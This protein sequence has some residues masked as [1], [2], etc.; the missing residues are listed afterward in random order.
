M[1]ELIS[2][3]VPC[4]NAEKTIDRCIKSVVEQTYK[5]WELIIVDDG[6]KDNSVQHVHK[7][8]TVDN[9][10]IFYGQ[11]NAGV[12]ATRNKA[13][14]LARGAYLA[15]LD[16]DDWYEPCFLQEL[17]DRLKSNH[18]DIACCAYRID[19]Q[20]EGHNVLYGK[21]DATFYG[22]ECLQQILF[23]MSVRGF[24]SN[25][26]FKASTIQ[27]F[28]F[29]KELKLCEDMYLLCES[30]SKNWVMAYV[31]KA[32]YHYWIDGTGATQSDNVLI[33]PNGGIQV[34]DTYK[35]MKKLF[36]KK[37][38]QLYF[39]RLSGDTIINMFQKEVRPEKYNK[40]EIWKQIREIRIPYFLTNA[41]IKNKIKF[42]LTLIKMKK[43]WRKV[44]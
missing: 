5:K 9:R 18:A 11:S 26:L 24:M 27:N 19:S 42:G 21:G 34:L 8:C 30:Y 10:I 12:S 37:E 16:S 25:K 36:H 17:Y 13:M 31:D 14:S 40:E 6:S 33:S 20:V 29:R 32:L 28:Q 4:Y 43:V 7:W 1:S 23:G 15:F 3:V 44:K 2:I 39:I 38:E 22:K 35:M 41:S